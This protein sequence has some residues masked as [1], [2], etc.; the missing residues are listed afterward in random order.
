M[1]D[2][3]EAMS[4]AMKAQFES[5]FDMK[6]WKFD[7]GEEAPEDAAS[8]VLNIEDAVWLHRDPQVPLLCLPIVRPS[9]S[10]L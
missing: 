8:A 7:T 2:G 10:F 5:G 4:E 1:A 3:R 9:G 6:R